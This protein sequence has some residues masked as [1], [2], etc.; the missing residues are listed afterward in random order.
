MIRFLPLGAINYLPRPLA[1]ARSTENAR[2]QTSEKVMESQ[3]RSDHSLGLSLFTLTVI[4][5]LYRVGLQ[6]HSR[7]FAQAFY[8]NDGYDTKNRTRM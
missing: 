5:R 8:R 2:V 3:K 4:P 7:F 1:T 6:Y